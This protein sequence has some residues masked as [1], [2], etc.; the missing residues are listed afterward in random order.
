MKYVYATIYSIA[1]LLI[2]TLVV[3][4]N[5]F[6]TAP[7]VLGVLAILVVSAVV[8]VGTVLVMTWFGP[9]A[10]A[11]NFQATRALLIEGLKN[12]EAHYYFE[13]KGGGILF[14]FS[15][16]P[17]DVYALP[18]GYSE[19]DGP[20]FP[21]SDFSLLRNI[22]TGAIVGLGIH[23]V[24][25]K[26]EKLI[27]PDE[28]AYLSGLWMKNGEVAQGISYDEVKRRILGE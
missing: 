26:P 16:K 10:T 2:M 12:E 28:E 22:N 9:N 11:T 20:L 13:L 24:F 27:V 3:T 15:A 23:G 4:G 8:F 1:A 6:E 25:I 19:K 7:G 17:L 14:L 5:P 21:N 18:E